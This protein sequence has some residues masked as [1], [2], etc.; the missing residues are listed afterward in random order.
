MANTINYTCRIESDV[1]QKG[2][3]LFKELGMSLSTAINVF[4]KESIRKGGFPFDVCLKRP[5]MDT[6]SAMI[7]SDKLLHDP[8]TKKYNVED[9]LKELKK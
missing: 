7:E 8:D 1:K 6:L 4:L 9:S 2:E 5:N 3:V